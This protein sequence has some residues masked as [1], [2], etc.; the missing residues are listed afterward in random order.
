MR[1]SEYLK[2]QL[3]ILILS[4]SAGCNYKLDCTNPDDNINLLKS[5]DHGCPG[6]AEYKKAKRDCIQSNLAAYAMLCNK[7]NSDSAVQMFCP[8]YLFSALG[9]CPESNGGGF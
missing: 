2:A 3:V 6:S 7:P 5:F 9:G 4:M 8:Q 1:H